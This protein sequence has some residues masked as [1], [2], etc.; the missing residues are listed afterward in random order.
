MSALTNDKKKPTIIFSDEDAKACTKRGYHN[1]FTRGAVGCYQAH[2]DVWEE[3]SQMEEGWHL[4]FEDDI[5]LPN[6][7]ITTITD[8]IAAHMEEHDEKEMIH[9]GTY[10]T[11]PNYEATHAYAVTPIGAKKLLDV[12]PK[13]GEMDKPID[14]ITHNACRQKKIACAPHSTDLPNSA[15]TQFV[16]IIKQMRTNGE[17][18]SMVK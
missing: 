18:P 8:K 1:R 4:I 7:P 3:I 6:A 17:N 16:G 10:R 15:D 11:A 2:V 13:C 9:L 12:T 14:H 5:A